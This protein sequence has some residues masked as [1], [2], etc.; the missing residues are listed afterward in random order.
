MK[1]I[2]VCVVGYGNVGREAIECIRQA[3]DMELAGVVRRTPDNP[4]LDCPVVTDVSQLG[5]VD[6]AVLTVPSR[7]V[8]SIAPIYLKKG[9]NTVDSYDIHGDSIISLRRELGYCARESGSVAVIGAGW[10]PG[11]DSVVRMLFLAIAP[12]GITYTNF[13]PGMSMGHTVAVKSIPG[14]KN[15]LSMTLPAGFGQHRRD[16]YVELE[17]GA[18]F[19]EVSRRIKADPYFVHDETRITQVERITDVEAM[20]HGVTLE[21]FGSSG[22]AQNQVL[23]LRMRL[24]NP[25]ATAQVMVSA[26][27]A[28][29]RLQPGAYALGEIPP[30]DLLPGDRETLLKSLI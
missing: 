3:P 30:I 12:R 13:G 9:I 11:T 26:A 7:Q 21:R 17:E 24:T 29:T 5:K 28:S 22:T 16:V 20:G 23:E 10:D 4:G 19:S 2:R 14:V 15:A 25:A 6:V 18:D 27:R 8:P 1:K